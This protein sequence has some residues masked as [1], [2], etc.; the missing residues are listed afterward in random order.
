M[1]DFVIGNLFSDFC[2]SIAA[3]IFGISALKVWPL[4]LL[5]FLLLTKVSSCSFH[6][7]STAFCT[8]PAIA[9]AALDKEVSTEVLRPSN[10]PLAFSTL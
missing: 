2:W 8:S 1:V 5:N 10:R 9:L 4:V 6:H 3:A 7:E